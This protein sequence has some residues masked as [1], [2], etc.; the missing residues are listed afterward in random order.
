MAGFA[1]VGHLAVGGES[2]RRYWR[3]NPV[4]Q[5]LAQGRVLYRQQGP[6]LFDGYAGG[7]CFRDEGGKHRLA[8]IAGMGIGEELSFTSTSFFRRW[9]SSELRHAAKATRRPS[10]CFE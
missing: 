3:R 10:L 5:V 8:G 6:Y 4:T 1:Y 7:P 2:G 9:V